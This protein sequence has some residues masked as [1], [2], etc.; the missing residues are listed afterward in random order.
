M[1][2]VSDKQNLDDDGVPKETGATDKNGNSANTSGIKAGWCSQ[3]DR[4]FVGFWEE[5]IARQK[6]LHIDTVSKD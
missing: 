4:L 1:Q 6:E 5:H 3:T 2:V